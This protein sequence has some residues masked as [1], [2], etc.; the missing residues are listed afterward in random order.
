MAAQAPIHFIKRENG[1]FVISPEAVKVL[2]GIS[3]DVV[4]IAIIGVYRSGKSVESMTPFRL[5]D[6]WEFST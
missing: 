1:Q 4:V 5:I 6:S 2:K 3:E